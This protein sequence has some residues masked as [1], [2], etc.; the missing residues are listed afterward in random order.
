MRALAKTPWAR[1]TRVARAIGSFHAFHFAGPR[2]GLDAH[3]AWP[4]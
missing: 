4:G 1:W 2:R 3:A